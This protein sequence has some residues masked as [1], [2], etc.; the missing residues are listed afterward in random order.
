MTMEDNRT[1]ADQKPVAGL[2]TDLVTQMNALFRTEISLLKSEMRDSMSSLRGAIVAVAIG[3][4]LLLA[5]VVVIVQ[6]IVAALVD[7]GMSVWLA[8]L[9]V[10][11]VL[12]V[13]GAIMMR[14]GAS[15]MS[16]SGMA[17]DRTV[18]SVEKDMALVKETAK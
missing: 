7:A 16:P 9:I 1:A 8:S 5:A 6:A 14:S 13:I 3:A 15:K 4:A 11:V 10:G 2:L 12:A 18:R 17:P